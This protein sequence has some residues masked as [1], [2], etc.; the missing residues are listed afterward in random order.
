MV[1]VEVEET[2]PSRAVM[3]EEVEEV[4][5]AEGE[6]PWAGRWGERIARRRLGCMVSLLAS[7]LKAAAGGMDGMDGG[8]EARGWPRWW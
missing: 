1:E 3:L 5:E 6:R 4:E 8:Q 2:F 7:F